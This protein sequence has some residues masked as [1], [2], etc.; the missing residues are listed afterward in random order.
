MLGTESVHSCEA[1]PTEPVVLKPKCKACL[2]TNTLDDLVE[3][4]EPYYR[5]CEGT[6]YTL[7]QGYVFNKAKLLKTFY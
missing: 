4:G 6:V 2:K 1:G 3:N 5:L 7:L